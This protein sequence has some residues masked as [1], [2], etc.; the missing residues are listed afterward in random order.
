MITRA[1]IKG[2]LTNK[3]EASKRKSNK[4]K[5]KKN[6]VKE[7]TDSKMADKLTLTVD[8][9]INIIPN[10]DGEKE[11]NIENYINQ[12]EEIAKTAKIEENIQI[13]LIKSKFIGKARD[14]LIN[15]EDLN[16]EQNYAAFKTKLIETFKIDKN[17]SEIQSKFME[18]KQLPNQKIEEF[19]KQFNILA[20][21]YLKQSG[22]ATKEGAKDLLSTIKLSRFIESIRPDIALDVRKQAP[23]TFEEAVTLAKQ[24]ELALETDDAE[25]NTN[26]NI[27]TSLLKLSQSQSE[28]I[29]NLTRELEKL[30]VDKTEQEKKI[31]KIEKWCDI[32]KRKSHNTDD[33]W[34][35]NKNTKSIQ[36][37]NA[38]QT[39]V[40]NQLPNWQRFPNQIQYTP[41]NN[42]YSQT[43][44]QN[45]YNPYT[46]N[47]R[48][49][50]PQNITPQ[51]QHFQNGWRT[52]QPQHNYDTQRNSRQN[53]R[54]N[55]RGNNNTFTRRGR[56]YYP[57]VTYPEN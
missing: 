39:A 11:N 21:K 27:C 25:Q 28:Q 10:F 37:T 52:Q 44:W 16:N 50:T 15:S 33:C 45:Q 8:T 49:T 46:N 30:R 36:K 14:L 5:R 9:L 12:F 19:A 18:Y 7:K 38:Q 1:R 29:N 51:N 43:L 4:I 41:Q 57:S 26:N 13:I 35:N 42:D 22:H 32:C 24:I 3:R 2:K 40:Q 23:K 53:N 6:T 48:A 56:T 17:F 55:F 34:H 54:N 20:A 47:F 31:N